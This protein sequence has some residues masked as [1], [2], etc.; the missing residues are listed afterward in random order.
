[1]LIPSDSY[2]NLIS[3]TSIVGAG[4]VGRGAAG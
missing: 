4:Q 1:M 3:T 2:G